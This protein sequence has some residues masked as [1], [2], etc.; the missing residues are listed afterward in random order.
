MKHI[1][2][3]KLLKNN[4]YQPNV[5]ASYIFLSPTNQP[6]TID[7]LIFL[8]FCLSNNEVFSKRLNWN[9][10]VSNGKEYDRYDNKYA[11]YIIISDNHEIVASV[12]L[13]ET[14]YPHLL[15][16]PFG[17]FFSSKHNASIEATRFF[18]RKHSKY[19]RYPLCQ[20]LLSA[21]IEYCLDKQHD[22]IVAIVG[23]GMNKLLKKYGWAHNVIERC[24]LE[25][26]PIYLI[27]LP[28]SL[29]VCK[30]IKEK[31]SLDPGKIFLPISQ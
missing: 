14:K 29:E 5:M 30:K 22:S 23:S 19:N 6:V 27:N 25:N 12:R 3:R 8:F 13:I 9:V 16:G 1:N 7:R 20:I 15:T 2:I 4:N 21:M 28:I 24:T 26:K 10:T 31:A 11:K 17:D 18:V